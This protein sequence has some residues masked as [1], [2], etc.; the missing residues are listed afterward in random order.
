MF[1]AQKISW[2]ARWSVLDACGACDE[3]KLSRQ[4][5]GQHEDAHRRMPD[6]WLWRK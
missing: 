2:L 5:R 4:R 6:L 1:T 3:S